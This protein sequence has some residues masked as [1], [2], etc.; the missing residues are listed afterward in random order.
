MNESIEELSRFFKRD[1][2]GRWHRKGAGGSY[3]EIE[4][5]KILKRFRVLVPKSVNRI[6]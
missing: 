2:E 3:E 6:E 5:S 4:T 1:Q